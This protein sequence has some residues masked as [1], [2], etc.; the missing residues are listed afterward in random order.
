M[1]IRGIAP[2]VSICVVVIALSLSAFQT[3]SSQRKT[4]VS[5]LPVSEPERDLLNEINQ[6]RAHPQL[7]ASYLEKLKPL[8]NGKDYT[9]VGQAGITTQEGWSAV[10]EAIKSLRITRPIAALSPSHG[11]YLAALAHVKDQSSNG[12]TGHRGTDNAF[13][14]QRV[15]PFG[16]WSGAIGENLTYGADSARAR[17][18]TWLI[19]DGFPSRGHRRRLLSGDYKV[20]GISCGPHPEYGAMCV[21][22]L[23]GSFIET[24]NASGAAASTKSTSQTKPMSTKS[25]KM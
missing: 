5:D 22:T 18:L 15:K 2:A 4:N 25:R 12:A 23:A 21:L 7:Y 8:F 17:V 6:C 16:V 3:A 11:L 10:E 24:Q 14:E 9:A 20:A 13:I 19:D 1:K